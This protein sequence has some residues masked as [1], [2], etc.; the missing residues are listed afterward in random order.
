MV[1]QR[2]DSQTARTRLAKSPARIVIREDA[3]MPLR[4]WSR[5]KSLP[6]A[7]RLPNCGCVA[8]DSPVLTGGQ[9]A[10]ILPEGSATF[11]G[12]RCS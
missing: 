7:L 4:R 3:R 10:K 6:S 12:Y 9:R 1:A 2:R 5:T 8:S 11:K